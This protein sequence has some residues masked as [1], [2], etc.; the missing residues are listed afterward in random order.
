MVGGAVAHPAATLERSVTVSRYSAPEQPGRCH[1]QIVLRIGTTSGITR[2]RSLGHCTLR[3]RYPIRASGFQYALQ[4]ACLKLGC[5][6][7]PDLPGYPSH[8]SLSW[9]LPQALASPQR[10]PQ[11]GASYSATAYGLVACPCTR[12][13]EHV[14]GFPVPCVHFA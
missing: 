3:S 14:T 7:Y 2:P 8:V 13:R 5:C 1:K 10:G 6:Q 12:P 9:A 4:S 11:V